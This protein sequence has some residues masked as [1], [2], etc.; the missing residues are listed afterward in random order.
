MR[1]ISASAAFIGSVLILSAAA[2]AADTLPWRDCPEN[3]VKGYPS[4][5]DRLQCAVMEVPLDHHGTVPGT[6]QIDVIR[7]RA[8][9]PEARRGV[10]LL[11]PGGPGLGVMQYASGVVAQ[12]EDGDPGGDGKQRISQRYDVIGVQPRGLTA[13]TGFRCQSSALLRPYANI[14]DD[15]SPENLM[16][17][18]ENAAVIAQ[19]CSAHPWSRFISTDQTARDMDLA[20]ERL[21]E[22]TINYWG[23]SYGTE[24]GAWYG[25]LFPD[26]VDRMI[27]DS[28][29]DWT[30][31]IQHTATPKSDS[32]QEIYRR[33]V[34]EGAIQHP[35]IYGLGSTVDEVDRRFLSLAPVFRN[36]V[37]YATGSIT[38]LMA[39]DTLQRWLRAD[40]T[41][42]EPTLRDRV[43]THRFSSVSKVDEQARRYAEDAISSWVAVPEE[44]APLD[45]DRGA[46]VEYAVLCNS[47]QGM[48]PPAFWDDFGDLKARQNPVGGSHESHAPCAY[49]P[50][51]AADRPAM[52]G[53]DALPNLM[54][55]QLEFDQFTPRTSAFNAF[56]AIPSASVVYVRGLFGHGLLY[57]GV[58]E[59]ADRATTAFMVDGIKPGRLHV[60]QHDMA[61]A[62]PFLQ[63]QRMERQAGAR[64]H[65]PWATGR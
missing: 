49:W 4:I 21:G 36:T 30:Q 10:L 5:S 43:T 58:S 28:N 46:S 31:G 32:R 6:L 16:A 48:A 51:P 54:V 7:I 24:L 18:N 61:Q 56:K 11:N 25:V 33:F 13:G 42:D 38:A 17:I 14:T 26:R 63:M 22:S 59:C 57:K 45:L 64:P 12:W 37:R 62:E 52:T 55:L 27:L 39:A 2:R 23:V 1:N 44:P 65:Q 34:A 53:L 50:A 29:V 19:G 40:P 15:R 60:C 41:L 8:R 3:L 47:S 20:R 35:E 9:Y